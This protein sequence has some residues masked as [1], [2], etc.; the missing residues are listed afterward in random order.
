[1]SEQ[2]Q[3]S[4]VAIFVANP[5]HRTPSVALPPDVA[6]GKGRRGANAPHEN[7]QFDSVGRCEVY[8]PE[9]AEAMRKHRGNKANG[10]TV[11]FE[12]PVEARRH[13]DAIG[14][15]RAEGRDIPDEAPP[16]PIEMTDADRELVRTLKQRIEKPLISHQRIPAVQEYERAVDRFGLCGCKKPNSA[17]RPAK[18]MTRIEDYLEALE[19]RGVSDTQ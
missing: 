3:Q 5:P 12:M 8:D 7:M 15:A 9:I 10:G 19:A 13:S 17:D 1:M 4:P 14:R 6:F 18:I 11:Y 2:Q 16:E